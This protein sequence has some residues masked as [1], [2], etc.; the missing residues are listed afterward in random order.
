MKHYNT[1]GVKSQRTLNT[2][3]PARHS[4]TAANR[5]CK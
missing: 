5:G 4:A 2:Q 1:L 3:T